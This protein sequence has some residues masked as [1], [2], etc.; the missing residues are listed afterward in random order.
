M[1][2]QAKELIPPDRLLAAD[3]N[4]IIAFMSESHTRSRRFDVSRIANLDTIP[5]AQRDKIFT[6]LM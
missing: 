3:E 1:V 4:E 2:A 6:K 5:V